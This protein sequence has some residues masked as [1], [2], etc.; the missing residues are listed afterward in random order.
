METVRTLAVAGNRASEP[1]GVMGARTGTAAREAGALFSTCR[2]WRY[3]LGRR[4]LTG[5]GGGRLNVIALN[6]STA[7]EVLD[8][9][10]IRRCIGFA[11]RLR[12]DELVVTNLFALR[13]TH[14]AAL[15]CH[16]DP[17]GPENDDHLLAQAEA[18]DLV[19]VAWGAQ[20][21]FRDRG[22]ET[23]HR[24]LSAGILP[25]CWGRTTTGQPRHPLY[26]PAATELQ[27]L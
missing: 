5:E 8:D 6:P 2:T 4:S 13:A 24:L 21:V 19:A 20:G 26:L 27:A 7:D 10:T 3:A 16:R 22:A 15:R 17:V 25:L 12:C 1:G 18:A 11:R 14:P 23:L 9:P